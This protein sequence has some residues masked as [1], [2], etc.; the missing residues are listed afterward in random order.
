MPLFCGRR[1]SK[2]WEKSRN[3]RSRILALEENMRSS[4]PR[5][6]VGR[7]TTGRAKA[8]TLS[9]KGQR[10]WEGQKAASEARAR[11]EEEAGNVKQAWLASE[12]V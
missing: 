8:K 2:P 3:K 11:H 1:Y 9:G 7:N 12:G 4:Q 5:K 6:V 10:A